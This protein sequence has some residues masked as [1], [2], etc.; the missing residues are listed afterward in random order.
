MAKKMGVDK[1]QLVGRDSSNVAVRM[2]QSETLIINQTK[3]WLRD[4]CGIDLS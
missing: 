1:S 4:D 2:A 3:E